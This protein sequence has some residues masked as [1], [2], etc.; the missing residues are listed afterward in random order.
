MYNLFNINICYFYLNIKYIIE[1]YIHIL[2]FGKNNEYWNIYI[3][4]DKVYQ[5]YLKFK[6]FRKYFTIQKLLDLKIFTIE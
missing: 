2:N 1:K 6:F 4:D 5:M 3:I